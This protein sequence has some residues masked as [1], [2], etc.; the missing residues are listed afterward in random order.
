[1][2][3]KLKKNP[4]KSAHAYMQRLAR[5]TQQKKLNTKQILQHL[6]GRNES[7]GGRRKTFGARKSLGATARPQRKGEKISQ[8]AK[9]QIL[10]PDQPFPYGPRPADPL[11]THSSFR[12]N[13]YNESG[14]DSE[15]DFV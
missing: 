3:G 7:Q 2:E 11:N 14:S 15:N 10:A 4:A 9:F 12:F 1:M 5:L 13:H 6:K 8:Q